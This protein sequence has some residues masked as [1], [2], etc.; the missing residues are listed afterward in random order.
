MRT[1]TGRQD[2]YVPKLDEV[3]TRVAD[4]VK[5]DKAAEMAKQRAAAIAT[6]LK[7]AKDF[8][9]A[10]KKA[11]LEVKTTELDR[12]RHRRFPT[13]ASARSIDNVGVRAAAGRRQRRDHDAHGTAIVRVVEKVN[14]TDAE[15][16]TGKDQMRD[17][18]VNQRRDKFF[19]AYM[20]KAKHEPEDHDARRHARAR[21]RAVVGADEPLV[22]PD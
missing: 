8:A 7:G 16:E 21:R 2:A 11:G 9:A 5:Q 1:V 20:Q 13:S 17:E 10:A 12:A 6:E 18:L 4:D 19:G 14:V 15:V 22:R 3:K